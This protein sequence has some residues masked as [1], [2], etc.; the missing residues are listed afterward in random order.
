[1]I[2]HQKAV[3]V[4]DQGAHHTGG[5]EEQEAH[6][7]RP[8][9][10]SPGGWDQVGEFPDCEREGGQGHELGT[11]AKSMLQDRTLLGESPALAVCHHAERHS[12]EIVE[13]VIE[14]V[15]AV[16]VGRCTVETQMPFSWKTGKKKKSV[17]M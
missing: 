4:G 10:R 6:D 2:P 13:A 3:R 17:Q 1:M 16:I 12:V 8:D 5:G 11:D 14:W 15:V 7:G 9:D